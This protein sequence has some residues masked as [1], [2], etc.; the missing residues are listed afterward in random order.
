[1]QQYQQR[2]YSQATTESDDSFTLHSSDLARFLYPHTVLQ[3]FEFI[4]QS[5]STVYDERSNS[6]SFRL[7]HYVHILQGKIEEQN[8]I[9]A[10]QNLAI[11]EQSENIKAMK[12]SLDNSTQL[13]F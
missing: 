13:N 9:I 5:S 8:D 2:R 11:I 10:A 12:R 1:M 7:N 6:T 3:N 4:N